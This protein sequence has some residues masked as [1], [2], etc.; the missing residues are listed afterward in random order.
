MFVNDK[1]IET[2]KEDRLG[3]YSFSSNLAKSLMAWQGHESLVVALYGKWGSGKSSVINLAKEY[4]DQAKVEEKPTIIEFNPWFFSGDEKIN[5]HF[6]IE[7]AK[8]LEV[9]NESE[10]DIKLAHRLRSYS[11]LLGLIPDKGVLKELFEKVFFIIGLFGVASSG[12]LQFLGITNQNTQVV[13]FVLGLLFLILSILKATTEKL[14]EY[15]EEKSKINKKPALSLKNDIKE[16]LGKRPK[17]ILIIIDDIDR[18]TSEEIRILFKLIKINTDFPNI[19]YLL[20]FDR[21]VIQ[22][23]LD[24]QPGK[25]GKEYIEKIIQVNFDIPF[26]RQEKIAQMLF[27]ELDRIIAP[28]PESAQK[29]FEKIYW[30]N[31]YHSGFKDLFRN[32]RDVKRFASSLEFNFSIMIKGK[33]IEVNPIDFIA[34]EA[35]RIFVP[36]FYEF[37]RTKNTL[38]TSNES[39]SGNSLSNP[40]KL[41]LEKGLKLL[42]AKPETQA[43]LKELISRLF[44]QIGGILN[45]GHTSHGPSWMSIW[46]QKLRI[47]SPQFFDVYFTLIP[48]GGELELSQFEVDQI[49]GEVTNQAEFER[50]VREFLNNGKIRK[51]L[52]RLQDYTDN[53]TVIPLEANI[54]IVQALFNISDELPD[55]RIGMLDLGADF[56]IPRIIYQLLKRTNDKNINFDILKQSIENSRGLIGP[57]NILLLESEKEEKQPILV[58]GVKLPELYEVCVKKITEYVENKELIRNK[59][60]LGILLRWKDWSLTEGWKDYIVKIAANDESLISF[61]KYFV[62]DRFIRSVEDYVSTNSK[63]FDFKTI[64]IFLPVSEIKIRLENIKA[65]SNDLYPNNKEIID[66]FVEGVD[67]FIE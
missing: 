43:Q 61:L 33:S 9:K 45:Q 51:F 52:N 41:E 38:F 65:N 59:N 40:R 28:L 10:S 46:N 67:K 26:T 17:K 7:L 31:V 63:Q 57:I 56:E 39:G 20:S 42:D 3:R 13:L 2:K 14:A 23:A 35:I 66:T 25:R 18:L 64:N 4:I 5:E 15:F 24:E 32:I 27:L 16:T 21:E 53:I 8:E 6:Y 37:M 22:E 60:F 58:D 49:L 12:V 34:I 19:I 54:N 50:I 36:E 29:L 47:C 62:T 44:P 11:K 48:G 55:E 30:G 1:P